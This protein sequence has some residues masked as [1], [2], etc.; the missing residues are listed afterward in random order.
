MSVVWVN[1]EMLRKERGVHQAEEQCFT[2]KLTSLR[3]ENRKR[4]PNPHLPCNV[5]LKNTINRT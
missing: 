2:Q 5:V 4:N 3:K 1:F